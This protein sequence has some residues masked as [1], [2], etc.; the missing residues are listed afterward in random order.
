MRFILPDTSTAEVNGI[1]KME[2]E[3]FTVS[4]K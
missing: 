1:L 4:L 2:A 3:G